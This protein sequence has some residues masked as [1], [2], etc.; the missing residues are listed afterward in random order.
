MVCGEAEDGLTCG[1]E[2]RSDDEN[3][4]RLTSFLLELIACGIRNLTLLCCGRCRGVCQEVHRTSSTAAPPP[5]SPSLCTPPLLPAHPSLSH[6][7]SY[8]SFR[9][10]SSKAE[11]ERDLQ[12]CLQEISHLSHE[13]G[14]ADS[15]SLGVPIFL[16]SVR[17]STRDAEDSFPSERPSS[18]QTVFGM[19]RGEI[20]EGRVPGGLAVSCRILTLTDPIKD[21]PTFASALLR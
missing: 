16:S 11:F 1:E 2:L 15:A 18:S 21:T 6:L 12:T 8:L 7:S 19:L 17:H 14:S 9:S 4:S 20:E 13:G 10:I 5:Y 3:F